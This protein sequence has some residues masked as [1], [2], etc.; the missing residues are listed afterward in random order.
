MTIDYKNYVINISNTIKNYYTIQ[1]SLK[2]FY[3]KT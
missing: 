3:N 1:F 2:A